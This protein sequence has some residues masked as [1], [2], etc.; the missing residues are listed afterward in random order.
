MAEEIYYQKTADDVIKELKSST[1][2]LSDA[3]AAKRLNIY[4]PNEI[5]E[6][7]KI[8]AW[9]I[10]LSQFKSFIIYILVA[11]VIISIL[12][13]I[14][15]KGIGNLV[16]MDFIDAIAIFV[17]LVLNAVMGFLQ[18]YKA[19]KAIEALKKLASLHAL[20]LRNGKEKETQQ[21]LFQET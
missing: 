5:K 16:V 21:M 12:V 2:G 11:A 17:I 8:S 6:E 7:K 1:S 10:F 13:P 14:Y 4:G 19:E 9:K 18:E 15:E 3:E 20:V